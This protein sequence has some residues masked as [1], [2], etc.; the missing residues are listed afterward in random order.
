MFTVRRHPSNPF[1]RP[2]HDTP[3]ESIAAFN[4]SPVQ[5]GDI[6]HVVYRAAGESD[7]YEGVPNFELSTIAVATDQGDGVY[8]DHRQLIVPEHD[9]ELFG[10]EDP[11]VTYFEGVYYIFYT[12]IGKYPFEPSGIRVALATS[13]DLITIDSKHLI[14]PFNA[15]A[16]TLFPERVGGKL[17]AVLTANSDLPPSKTGIAL[18]DKPED[19]F[20]DDFWNDWYQH[21]DEHMVDLSRT[22]TDHPE[23]GAAP[24]RTAEGWLLLYAH[25]EDYFTDS[26]KFGIEAALLDI[27][28]PTTIIS[29]T[30]YP[31]MVP[32]ESYEK[33]GRL[34][35]IIFPSGMALDGDELSIYYGSTDTV[36]CRATVSLTSLLAS[37]SADGVI[38]QQ[39]KRYHNNPILSPIAE[40]DWESSHVLNPAAIEIDGDIY[41]L[42]RAVGVTNTSVVG[43]AR[44]T[45]GFNIVERLPEPIYWPR[46]EFEQKHGN[47]TDNS[48][49]EDA[50]VVRIDD[51]LHITYTAYD[52]VSNPK[53]AT[54]S[55]SITDFL[56]H[57][58]NGWNM[59]ELISPEG[60]DD[61]D[62]AIIPEKKNGRYMIL[63][64]I[65]GHICADY[66]QSLDFSDHRLSRCIQII[67]PRPGMWD[68]LKVGIA[69]PPI[70]TP[71]GWLLFYHAVAADHSYCL[72]AALLD[73]NDHT[74]VIGRSV[75]PLMSPVEPWERDGW[76]S[77]VVFP[78]GQ[79][80][81]DGTVYLYY[82]GAD[83]VVAVA[84]IDLMELTN[85]LAA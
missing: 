76:I 62:A 33:Y 67:G 5:V 81:K 50:R 34:P 59:P 28:D 66:V 65:N 41:I 72:G 42:Y 61:K 75:L 73:I 64:R 1:V 43:L 15:K 24:V 52:S 8:T 82:G 80:V 2:E 29:R 6:R 14:T 63:H 27:N 38:R 36:C 74:K 11:R 26:K 22:A 3:W 60:I 68:A 19:M 35:N 20:S 37:L 53:V 12:A 77:N 48:G 21:I 40:H 16:M 9:W 71:K 23:V 45:D 70:Q 54:S 13:R 4:P 47:P 49:C 84:T 39:V 78:C 58:W 18:F 83:H 7:Y 85:S 79:I 10:C 55:I 57:N 31:F 56:A 32:E 46:A 51:R 69:G 30:S 17:C 25:I 44:S